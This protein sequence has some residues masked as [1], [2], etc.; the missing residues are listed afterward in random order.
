MKPDAELREG[1][2]P[3]L[4]WDPQVTD[5]D[6]IAVAAKDGAVTLTG[7]AASPDPDRVDSYLA[8]SP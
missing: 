3:E 4:A 7:R 5:P 2:I 1:V 6:A 8:V